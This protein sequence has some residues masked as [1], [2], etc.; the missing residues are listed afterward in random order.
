MVGIVG[1]VTINFELCGAKNKTKVSEITPYS[2]IFNFPSVS[3]N[4]KFI[5]SKMAFPETWLRTE[6][7]N[8]LGFETNEIVE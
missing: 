6:L 8:L 1:C 4:Y 2:V 5:N 3:L 7:S